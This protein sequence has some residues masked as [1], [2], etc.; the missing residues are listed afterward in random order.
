M[1]IRTS[2]APAILALATVLALS[3][4]GNKGPLVLPDPA[5]QDADDD[6]S[7]VT[8]DDAFDDAQTPPTDAGDDPQ[9]DD[10]R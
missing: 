4:C 9:D 7:A 1:T 5:A 8:T 3:A 6:G 10:G 2:I